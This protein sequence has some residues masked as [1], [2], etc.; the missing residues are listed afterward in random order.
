MS[1]PDWFDD[2]ECRGMD[3]DV[4]FPAFGNGGHEAKQVC[5]RCPVAT[6]CA[7]AGASEE[8]GVWG[9]QSAMEGHNGRARTT[10]YVRLET[11]LVTL[12]E[13]RWLTP[14]QIGDR[15]GMSREAAA[16]ALYRLKDQG[17]VHNDHGYW[18]ALPV[19]EGRTA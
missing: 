15:L 12:R 6:Q 13:H 14:R 2:A 7:E 18:W 1:R 3:P 19:D 5:A 17:L 4:F 16:R 11:V 8:F 9:G 10:T